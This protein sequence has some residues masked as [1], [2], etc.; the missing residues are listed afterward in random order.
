MPCINLR[1]FMRKKK[2]QNTLI[3]TFLFPKGTGAR[4]SEVRLE[5]QLED[6]AKEIK[7]LVSRLDKALKDKETLKYELWLLTF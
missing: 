4:K 6:R 1:F 3:K 2:N 7:D 5:K